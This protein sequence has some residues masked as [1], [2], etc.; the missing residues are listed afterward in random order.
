MQ[1]PI[2]KRHQQ[3]IQFNL[4]LLLLKQNIIIVKVYPLRSNIVRMWM[5]SH[6]ILMRQWLYCSV[7]ILT[8]KKSKGS[9]ILEQPLKRSQLHRD[10]MILC[11]DLPTLSLLLAL[12]EAGP[13]AQSYFSQVVTSDAETLHYWF[14]YISEI[15]FRRWDLMIVS[16]VLICL[17]KQSLVISKIKTFCSSLAN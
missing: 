9:S 17:W 6:V 7:K 1:C 12:V 16:T 4:L 14:I 15:L 5:Q 8:G 11:G 3:P 2:S 10:W 13:S